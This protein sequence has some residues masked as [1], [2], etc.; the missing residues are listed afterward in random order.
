MK[1][2]EE[3]PTKYKNQVSITTCPSA[4]NH[5]DNFRSK[6]AWGLLLSKMSDNNGGL[7][8]V[9]KNYRDIAKENVPAFN[10][11]H[12][13]N[14]LLKTPPTDQLLLDLNPATDTAHKRRLCKYACFQMIDKAIQ[15][16]LDQASLYKLMTVK[17]FFDSHD[18]N[19]DMLSDG[20]M[21]LHLVMVE[22]NPETKV[23]DQVFQEKI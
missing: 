15:C 7:K 17:T 22:R 3:L 1:A 11:T 13:E 10:D 20:A 9:I 18:S 5:F 8:D 23:G 14:G 2:T 19:G 12:L 4:K 16:H 21:V 6:N